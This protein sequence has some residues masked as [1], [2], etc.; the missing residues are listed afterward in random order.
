MNSKNTQIYFLLILLL[1]ILSLSFFI[2]YPF[3]TI[4][5]LAVV[6][7]VTFQP[8]YKKFLHLTR[9]RRGLAALLTTFIIVL[10]ILIPVS[11][12]GIQIVQE[13]QRI[14]LSLEGAGRDELVTAAHGVMDRFLGYL[15]TSVQFSVDVQQYAKLGASWL[16]QNI[17]G[18]FSSTA[19]LLASFFIFLITLFYMLKDGQGFKKTLID[20]SPLA[21]TNDEMIVHKLELAINSVMK[22]TLIIALIQGALTGIG[23]T[24]FGVPNAVLWG[25]V[26]AI[27]A[28]IPGI[29][30][31]LV[32]V[33]AIVFLFLTDKSLPALGLLLWGGIAVGL[34]DN[35]LGPKLVGKGIKLHPLWILLSVLGGVA[36]FGPIGFLMGPL[37]LSFLFAL[38]DIY[39]NLQK[40]SS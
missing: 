8:V 32:L 37:T 34:I 21:N 25:T 13:A 12:L 19:K 33:P 9:E 3:F 6:L 16:A 28:L 5:L 10:V 27:A 7:S 14:Y 23:F 30:T 22:G 24:L 35:I 40:S 15:P 17:G 2:F 39:A 1:G 4:I 20:I 38:L 31:T 11:L 26:A 36:L 29:G 18:I